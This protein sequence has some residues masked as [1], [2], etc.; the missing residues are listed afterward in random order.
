MNIPRNEYPRPQFVREKWLCLNGEWEFE[1][2]RGN[3]GLERGLLERPFQNRITVPFCPESTLSGIGDRD[4]LEAVWYRRSIQIPTSWTEEVLLHFQACDYDTT[5]WINGVECGRHR[6]G[7]TPFCFKVGDMRDDDG[8]ITITVRAQDL[9]R[10]HKPGGK[11][12]LNRFQHRGC[13]Y[14]RTTGIWQTVWLEP[15]PRT[16]LLRPRITPDL[17]GQSFHIVQPLSG[18]KN[19]QHF[20]ATLKIGD[21]VIASTTVDASLDLSPTC[22]LHIPS[23]E[24]H[25]WEPGNPFLYDLCF[26]L[27]DQNGSIIDTASGYAGMRSVSIQGKRLLINGKPLFQRQVLDQGFYPDGIMTAPDDNALKGDIELALAAGF[28]SARLHQKLFEE[29][30]LYH[31][32]KLGYL[33]WGEFGDWGVHRKSESFSTIDPWGH[34]PHNAFFRQWTEALERDYNHPSIVG[35]CPLNETHRF[36]DGSED[37][38][39]ALDDLTWGLYLVTKAIDPSRPVLDSSGYS[40]RVPGAD[41][42]DSHNYTQDPGQFATEMNGEKPYVNP[43]F[44]QTPYLEQ[45]YFCSEFGGIKWNP[46]APGDGWGYGDTPASLEEFYSR[47]EGLTS[48]LQENPD[49]FG[50]CYTQLTDVFQEQNGIYR[51][52]RSLKFPLERIYEAQTKVAA[53]EKLP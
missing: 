5:V 43:R 24:L 28:N 50:Y 48:V 1:I 2:D 20:R 44:V 37:E 27:L 53:Y 29:R 14:P 16:Y 4:F 11:Q 13:S 17:A 9:S 49:M 10:R 26:E 7:F 51:F 23:P 22:S 35:W 33:V 34:H 39:N 18:R 40:H 15:V 42:Y 47:F 32:D 12:Q 21:K 41:V 6:G 31:A 36:P 3:S 45:P 46:D 38:I 25:L 8:M 52:D 19:G 30:F